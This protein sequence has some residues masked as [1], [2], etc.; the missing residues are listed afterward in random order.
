[1]NRPFIYTQ[2]RNVLVR[3][4]RRTI[5]ICLSDKYSNWQNYLPQQQWFLELNLWR[6]TELNHCR[7]DLSYLDCS[8]NR[9]KYLVIWRQFHLHFLVVHFSDGFILY[10]AVQWFMIITIDHFYSLFH[11]LFLLLH[12]WKKCLWLSTPDG[13]FLWFLRIL[14]TST[15]LLSLMVL[16]LSIAYLLPYI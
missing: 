7:Y 4:T 5:R 16:R 13:W 10:H 9:I 6:L 3:D 8:N 2:S 1:M 14:F 12:R 11:S 15:T